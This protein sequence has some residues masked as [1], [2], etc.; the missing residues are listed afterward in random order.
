[1]L[2][3][4]H[5]PSTYEDSFKNK[6]FNTSA[7]TVWAEDR[8]FYLEPN[9]SKCLIPTVLKI[10]RKSQAITEIKSEAFVVPK[11][12]VPYYFSFFFGII[13]LNGKKLIMLSETVQIV[14]AIN[15]RDVFKITKPLFLFYNP[16]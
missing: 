1:M 6:D 10:D 15:S 9:Y 4:D 2:L 3:A 13:N 8:Y 7:L 12:A 11:A 14:C 5:L 16:E